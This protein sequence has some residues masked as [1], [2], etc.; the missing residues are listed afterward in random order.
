MFSTYSFNRSYNTH[1]LLV[2]GCDSGDQLHWL[3]KTKKNVSSRSLLI[4]LFIYLF[5]SH[6]GGCRF[7]DEF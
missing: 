4:N 5:L 2:I 7:N 3:F 1:I 6:D